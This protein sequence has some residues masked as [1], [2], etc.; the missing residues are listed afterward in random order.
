MSLISLVNGISQRATQ[1]EV[2]KAAQASM[3]SKNYYDALHKYQDLLEFEPNNIDYLHNAAEAGRLF[4][5][6][7]IATIL[8]DSVLAHPDQVKYPMASFWLGYAKQVRG[9]YEGAKQAYQLYLSGHSGEDAYYT[10]LAEKEVKACDWAQ[11]QLKNPVLGTTTTQ[12]GSHI[13]TIFSDFAPVQ[14]NKE[15]YFSS[16]RFEDRTKATLPKMHFSHI[17]K[18]TDDGPGE[19]LEMEVLKKPGLNI[20]HVSFNKDLNKV[21]FTICE[22]LN[23]LDKR[24]DI[25]RCD[26]DSS[27]QWSNIFKLP[28]QV[29]VSGKTATQPNIAY[30]ANL[31]KE[32]LYFVS[33]RDNGKGNLDIW[34]SI[35]DEDGNF[36]DALN[37]AALNTPQDD[38]TPFYHNA[39]NMLYY[40]SKG[41]LGMGGFD[42]YSSRDLFGDWSS[43]KHLGVPINS[44]LDDVYFFKKEKGNEA[45]L[46]SNRVGT[47]FID[48]L[49]EACCLDVFKA[50]MGPC[51]VTLKVLTFHAATLKELAGVTVSLY[52]LK[53]P[54]AEPIVLY[55]NDDNKFE[56]PILCDREYKVVA[57]KPGFLSD[58]VSFMSGKP[59]EFEEILKKLYLKPEKIILHA[60][61]FKRSTNAPLNDVRVKLQDLT[62]V[63]IPPI[64]LQYPDTNLHK[65]ELIR[66]HKYKL[67]ASKD[68][69][70]GDSTIFVAECDNVGYIEKRLFLDRKIYSF[71]PLGI[72]FDND[73]PNPATLKTVT[74][75]PYNQTYINYYNRK[76]V[77]IERY[78]SKMPKDKKAEARKQM[79]AFFE[80]SVKEGREKLTRFFKQLE[81]DLIDG[82]IYVIYLKGYASPLAKHSYNYNL[83]QRRISCVQNEFDRYKNGIFK[84][85]IKNGQLK[86]L[87]KSFGEETAPPG[88]SDNVKDLAKSIYTIEASKERRVEIIEIKE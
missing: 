71:L 30:S 27:G 56:F 35:I 63:T 40:S 59:G 19:K 70:T 42:I 38:V 73:H 57:S 80:D 86:V 1:S 60:L 54:L 64:T 22:N 23:D 7:K 77:F 17:L 55:R 48:E 82:R 36:S 46:A 10:A 8:Y 32:V 88:I 75:I 45:W 87:E 20:A 3:A 50:L 12:I 26:F 47:M 6:Y 51:E 24:C 13:N 18:S 78:T 76:P 31:N 9:D 15:L 44:S 85:Y 62:D 2:L 29:N 65:F 74:S 72:Y 66:C 43:I 41:H 53:N 5:S 84:K 61:T 68:G 69:Y 11:E 16:L 67:T 83:G 28:E 52:D 34:Y 25:Y 37:L 4:H 14:I 39:S 81:T 58:S 79:N 21:Y 33:D 49:S